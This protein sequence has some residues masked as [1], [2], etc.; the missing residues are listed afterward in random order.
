MHSTPVRWMLLLMTPSLQ[1]LCSSCRHASAAVGVACV[2]LH[3]SAK[4]VH[5][6]LLSPTWTLHE[7]ARWGPESLKPGMR[8]TLMLHTDPCDCELCA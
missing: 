5:H 4:H 2:L 3:V 1:R 7:H 8:Y 6:E